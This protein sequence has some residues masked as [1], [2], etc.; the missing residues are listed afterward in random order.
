MVWH[1]DIP[2]YGELLKTTGGK[3][4]MMEYQSSHRADEHQMPFEEIADL[5]KE[6]TARYVKILASG[7][8]ALR[9]GEADLIKRAC[10]APLVSGANAV[11]QSLQFYAK[12]GVAIIKSNAIIDFINISKNT[13]VSRSTLT[14]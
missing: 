5:H 8:L 4:R 6:K 14:A 10:S 9:P 2:I 12:L 3:E 11:S 1:W 13:Y 7:G